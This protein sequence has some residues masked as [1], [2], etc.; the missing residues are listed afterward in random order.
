MAGIKRIMGAL[1]LAI[2][3]VSN[4]LAQDGPWWWHRKDD[5][6]SSS[7]SSSSVGSYGSVDSV[8]YSSAGEV[9]ELDGAMLLMV[10]ALTMAMIALAREWV[11]IRSNPAGELR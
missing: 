5:Q 6:G 10:V 7:S 1:F 4:A 2:L 9:P 3:P 8:D 11:S